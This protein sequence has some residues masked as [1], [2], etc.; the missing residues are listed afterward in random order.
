MKLPTIS[1]ISK[2]AVLQYGLCISILLDCSTTIENDHLCP[3]FRIK[4]PTPPI[5]PQDTIANIT[6][7][8]R[9]LWGEGCGGVYKVLLSYQ[10]ETRIHIL[11]YNYN[12][13]YFQLNYEIMQFYNGR[14]FDSH[15]LKCATLKNSQMSD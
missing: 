2:P 7:T 6:F 3:L 9:I 15:F 14:T 11:K 1:L 8:R 10:I 12:I 13:I 4:H 5:C